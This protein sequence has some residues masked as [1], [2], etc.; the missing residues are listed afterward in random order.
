M[1]RALSLLVACVLASAGLVIVMGAPAQ[2][3]YWESNSF[4]CSGPYTTGGGTSRAR[5]SG[6]AN[7]VEHWRGNASTSDVFIRK[8]T[9]VSTSWAY[10]SSTGH[11]A[12]N[13]SFI[14]IADDIDSA[15]S[16]YRCDYVG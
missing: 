4:Y 8:W 10:R 5:G 7:L 14:V 1:R 13:Q 2:A 15:H 9:R 16:S 6:I 3:E 11:G 12:G